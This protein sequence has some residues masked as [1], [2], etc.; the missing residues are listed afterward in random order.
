MDWCRAAPGI[1]RHAVGAVAMARSTAGAVRPKG[2]T[3]YEA[4]TTPQIVLDEQGRPVVLS[5]MPAG[6]DTYTVVIDER[7]AHLGLAVG[8]EAVFSVSHVRPGDDDTVRIDDLVALWTRSAA[9]RPLIVN[10]KDPAYACGKHGLALQFKVL[11]VGSLRAYFYSAC[12]RIDKLVEVR[13]H[14]RP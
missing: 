4:A 9:S 13:P 3:Q 12:I 7:H 14:V 6:C 5:S 2:L 8:A 11:P 1:R 10:V